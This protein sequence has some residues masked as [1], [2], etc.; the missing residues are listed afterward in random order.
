MK[1]FIDT[2]FIKGTQSRVPLIVKLANIFNKAKPTIDL[3]SIGI[4][5]EEPDDKDNLIRCRKEGSV[6]INIGRP[7]TI[8][9]MEHDISYPKKQREY[10]AISKDFNL[11]EAW[12][13]YDLVKKNRFQTDNATYYDKVYWIRDNLLKPIYKELHDKE[14]LY[15]RQ[16]FRR[17]NVYIKETEFKF[18]YKNLKR[19]I[20]K[21]GK[22]NKQIA[23]DI[24]CFCNPDF[25]NKYKSFIGKLHSDDKPIFYGYYSDC[26]WVVFCQLFGK[27]ID[28]PKGFP[29][30]C[31]DL[32]QTLDEKVLSLTHDQF[33]KLECGSCKHDVLSYLRDTNRI[34]L[35][36]RL[37]LIKKHPNYPKKTNEHNALSDAKWTYKLY[38]FLNNI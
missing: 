4:V 38:K 22:T 15:A 31:I 11:K 35:N 14:N 19:L 8:D 23:D 17:A 16:A 29:M 32:K 2:E 18:T 26:D 24:I 34:D 37:E 33:N 3:I 20:D 10:Y 30:Y 27:M 6:R 1:Y 36:F 13:R 28:L 25:Y 7:D 5:C 12:Y 21:Y 9:P